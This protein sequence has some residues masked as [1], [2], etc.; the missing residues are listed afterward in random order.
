[1][2]DCQRAL[3]RDEYM[4]HY[5]YQYIN[6]FLV[7]YTKRVLFSDTIFISSIF[8]YEGRAMLGQRIRQARERKGWSQRAL[9]RQA[10][11]RH[12]IISELETGKKTDTIGVILKRLARALGVSVDYLLETFEDDGQG[13]GELAGAASGGS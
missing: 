4:V 5:T 11:V 8:P 12:A 6:K 3:L 2:Q 7:I 1:M 9:A 13:D 10:G